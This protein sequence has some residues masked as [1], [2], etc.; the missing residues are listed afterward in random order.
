[1]RKTFASYNGPKK[2]DKGIAGTFFAGKRKLISN[3][4]EKA[5]PFNFFLA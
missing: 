3:D 5:E 1:M 2:G 4:T